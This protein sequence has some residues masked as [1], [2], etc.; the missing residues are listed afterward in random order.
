MSMIRLQ[1]I[2]V[3]F[4]NHVVLGNVSLDIMAGECFVIVGPSG[5]GKTTLLKT[6]SGLITPQNGKVFIEQ[7]DWATLGSKQRLPVL[8]RMGILFQKNA[9]FD[10][11]TCVENI[12]FPLRETTKLTD[13]EITKKAE[14]FLDAV[15][16]PHAR[17]LYPDEISGGMQK[18]LGIA[19]ALA[20]DPEIIFYDDPT[21]GLDPITSKKI[22]ELILK[23]KMEK[24]STVV[25]IT[26]DMNRAYQ[27]ADRIGVVVDQQ[28]IITGTPEQ[29]Q[30]H[31]DP[32]VHQFV[33]GL[34]EGP[35]TAMN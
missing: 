25:A 22:I 14:Y 34:L 15:G 24:K 23:L 10:S 21:A 35:L 20:L 17:D 26:N 31:P 30:N 13:W 6:M 29:T 8:K 18:R 9:L 11:L 4:D 3:A 5:Q 27:M 7:N 2:K 28:L 32:R 19:R 16:I 33:R 1:D 12:C